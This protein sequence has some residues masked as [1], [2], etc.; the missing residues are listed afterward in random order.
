MDKIR[1]GIIGAGLWGQAHAEVYSTH[2]ASELA[3]VCDIDE[4]KAKTLASAHGTATVYADYERMVRDPNVDAVA[5][6]T[7]DF[8]HCGPI[9]AAARAGKHVIVEKPLATTTED[10]ERIVD[11]VSKAGITLMVDFH[12]RWSPPIVVTRNN[13][14]NHSLGQL[15]SAYVRLNDTISVPT[16]MLSWASRSSILWFLGSHAV[17]TLR[18]LSGDEVERVFTVSRSEVLKGMGIDVP[19]IYQSILEFR[20]GLIATT[21]NNWIVP[22]TNPSVNDFKVNILGSKGMISLDLMHNNLIERYLDGAA[23]HPDI[24]VGPQIHGRHEGFAY[25][26][27]RAFVDCLVSGKPVLSSLEDGIRVSKVILAMLQSAQEREP[28]KICY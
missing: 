11:E 25:D 9:V 13:I 17:D 5:V 12:N 20:S 22:N 23:D 8:A 14:E 1:F 15:I 26:S 16:K 6:V 28:V 24:L 19:D 18:Y 3:A 27:I 4:R 10:L 7:P 2:P 21:E